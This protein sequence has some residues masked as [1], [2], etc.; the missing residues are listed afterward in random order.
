M[1]GRILVTGAAG[2]IGAH[3]AHHLVAN[4]YQV[5]LVDNYSRGI[6]DPYL[7]ALL[8]MSGTTFS[9]IDLLDRS[10]VLK[11]GMDYQAIFHLAAIIGVTHV[12]ERPYEVMNNNVQILNNVILLAQEQSNLSRLLFASTSEVY[13]G[14]LKYFD[15]IVPSPENSPLTVTDVKNPRTAYMLSKIV[16][17]AMCHH[18]GIPFTIFRPHNIYGP[19]MGMA[20][21]IPELLKK[22]WKAERGGNIDVYSVDHQRTFC[23]ID[24]AVEMLKRMLEKNT[25]RGQTLN[26]GTQAP[27]V[28]IRQLA[29]I[30]IDTCGK[31]LS[32]KPA[33]TTCGSPA[34]RAP[35]MSVVNRLLDYESKIELRDGIN[36]T[37][38]WYQENVFS[39]CGT[40]AQ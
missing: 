30:C 17:E 10:A 19:R 16:G 26:L 32:I 27:E 21:V 9:N 7:E 23:Y 35:D 12:S 3:L 31:A 40:S 2:F 29:N 8:S 22:A 34:R 5:H 18:S 20:H 33:A 6:R 39:N 15:L 11:L 37:W 36:R 24:D 28:T 4:G 13:A 14:T 25:C 38:K 1:N